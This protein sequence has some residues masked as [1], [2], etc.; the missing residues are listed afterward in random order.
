M[1]P[2]N[3]RTGPGVK[4]PRGGRSCRGIGG[5]VEIV[6]S[7][8]GGGEHLVSLRGRPLRGPAVR[9]EIGL[10]RVD[11]RAGRLPVVTRRRAPT[12]L[13]RVRGGVDATPGYAAAAAVLER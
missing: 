5:D 8:G 12:R 6:S 1:S 2:S 4:L 13:A 10:Q 3:G 11:P 7:R 9:L